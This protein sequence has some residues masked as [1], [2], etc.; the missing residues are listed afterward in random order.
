MLHEDLKPGSVLMGKAPHAAETVVHVTHGHALL[1]THQL[2]VKP[3]YLLLDLTE[4]TTMMM[5]VILPAMFSII[6]ALLHRMT[7]AGDAQT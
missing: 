5:I 3:T 1:V 4:T 2:V 6:T 7:G